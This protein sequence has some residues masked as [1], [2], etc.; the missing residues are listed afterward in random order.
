MIMTV[1]RKNFPVKGMGCAACVARVQNAIGRVRGVH[2]ASVSLAGNSARVDYDT[3]ITDAAT[4][5]KAVQDAGYD[6]ILP[7]EGDEDAPDHLEREEEAAEEAAEQEERRSYGSLR[8][9]M[10]LALAL[11]AAVMAIGCIWPFNGGCSGAETGS[12]GAAVQA[13]ADSCAATAPQN[14]LAGIIMAVLSAFSVFWAGRRFIRG[15]VRQA[16]H[17]GAG[18]DTLVA[19][20]TLIAWFFSLFNLLFPRFWTSRGLEAGLYFDSSAMIVAFIL[21][22]RV[23][24]ERARRGTTAAVRSL[25]GLRPR[26][27]IIRPGE[28]VQIR[29]GERIPV[30]GC[31]LEGSSFVDESLL[32]GEPLAVEKLPGAQVYAGSLNQG[33]A[34]SVKALKTGGDTMLSAIIRMVKDAQGSKARIQNIV[35]R[36]AAVFVPVIL[37]IAAVTFL[38]W[39]FAAADGGLA[40]GLLTMVSVLVIACPCSLGLATPTAVIAGIGKGASM[41]ILIKD[42]DALQSAAGID[43]VVLDKTGTLTTGHPAVTDQIWFDS[44]LRGALLSMERLSSHPLAEAISAAL[45]GVVPLAVENFE[46]VPGRGLQATFGG[47]HLFAGNTCPQP[48][49]QALQ[50]LSQG[51]TVIYFCREEALVAAL[52]VSDSLKEDSAAA[53]ASLDEMGIETCIL[54]GDNS[55]AAARIA[56]EAGIS[57]VKAGVLPAQKG[58]FI[59]RLQSEGKKVAMVGDGINDSA[60]LAIA[61]VSIAMGHG[62]DVAMDAAKVTIVSGSL[63]RIPAMIRLSRKSRRIIRE[64]LFWAFIYNIIA[65]PMAAGAFGFSLNPMI[66][67]CCMALSSVCV[68]CNSLRLFKDNKTTGQ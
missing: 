32:T 3:D 14:L 45:D 64:N 46:A 56:A 30:D 7:E 13:A 19:L 29:P 40:K 1:V 53:V 35:D 24:E 65:V 63:S 36:V 55:A 25:M 50:W 9:D 5:Q 68:V 8:R 59:S 38:W 39:T 22:G 23:L 34:L 18:M 66:A 26:Q 6:L 37:V 43:T 61:D 12:A 58:D 16:V 48:C 21:A 51:K 15:A 33:G 28:I 11:A 31:V 41:G 67:S 62:S 17:L 57:R 10:F 49:P 47:A 4:I 42:A 60:A 20:S 52:A 44:S 2:E 27:C 54:T